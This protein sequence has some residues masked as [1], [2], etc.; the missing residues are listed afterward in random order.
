MG[1]DVI[2][3]SVFAHIIVISGRTKHRWS[4]C[5]LNWDHKSADNEFVWHAC[6]N[7][8]PTVGNQYLFVLD[9]SFNHFFSFFFY[10]P[11][12]RTSAL[13]L[14]RNRFFFKVEKTSHG[15]CELV[16]NSFPELKLNIFRLDQPCCLICGDFKLVVKRHC[17][18]I[19]AFQET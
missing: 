1:T 9:G 11:T 12:L 5:E 17:H 7:H 10:T 8:K 16:S 14:P 13:L 2:W 18:V 4:R 3:A 6:S 19:P 15:G